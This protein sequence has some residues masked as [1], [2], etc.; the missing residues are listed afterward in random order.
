MKVSDVSQQSVSE[1]ELTA[2][3]AS[4]N[5]HFRLMTK[6]GHLNISTRHKPAVHR[7]YVSDM[8]GSL[9]TMNWVWVGALTVVS[10]V[11]SWLLF[12]S[13]WLGLAVA[14]GDYGR[15]ANDTSWEPCVI[16]VVDW[17]SAVFFSI[18]TQHTIGYGVRA[19]SRHCPQ[20]AVLL[21]IQ[22]LI[23]VVITSLL[24]GLLYAR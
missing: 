23:G 15:P 8:M 12:S 1:A 19:P 11:S 14:H 16:G 22:S 24:A 13:F 4:T 18:E 17:T 2:V 10:Y 5:T 3:H 9:L 20:A 21:V 7:R 6:T